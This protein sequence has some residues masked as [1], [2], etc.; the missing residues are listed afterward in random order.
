MEYAGEIKKIS[1]QKA[2]Y[3]GSDILSCL[4]DKQKD[5]LIEAKKLGYYDYQR[6]TN[7]EK[8]SKI[9]GISKS[10]VAEHL[11]KAESRIMSH[12]LVGY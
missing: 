12:I 7:L 6:K 4:T 2:S 8:V 10:T 3:Q 9:M 11:R 1:F 5:V